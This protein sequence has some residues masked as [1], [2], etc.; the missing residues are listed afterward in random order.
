MRKRPKTADI[1]QSL[2]LLNFRQIS[3]PRR[4][5][6]LSSLLHPA[7]LSQATIIIMRAQ[8]HPPPEVDIYTN[9]GEQDSTQ[10]LSTFALCQASQD[11]RLEYP[12]RELWRIF[13]YLQRGLGEPCGSLREIKMA[14]KKLKIGTWF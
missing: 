7:K 8:D 3:Q 6:F 11:T 14:D 9:K 4:I 5:G 13:F 10:K 2:I 12:Q 1:I